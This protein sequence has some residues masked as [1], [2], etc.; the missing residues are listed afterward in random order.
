M[1]GQKVRNNR[2]V[3]EKVMKIT[4]LG[5]LILAAVA[6]IVL[7]LLNSLNQKNDGDKQIDG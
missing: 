7:L 1:P 6:L 2:S 4:I 5:A 3:G